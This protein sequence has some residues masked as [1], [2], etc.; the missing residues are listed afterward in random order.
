MDIEIVPYK[1]T[2]EKVLQALLILPQQK[3]ATQLH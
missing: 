2:R 1:S 3:N